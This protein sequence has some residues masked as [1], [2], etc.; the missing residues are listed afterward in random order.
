M[1][2]A[3]LP[4]HVRS[5]HIRP[6]RPQPV[7]K[8]GKQF[9]A[10]IDPS[11]LVRETMVVAP[12]AFQVLQLFTGE[13]KLEDIATKVGGKPEQIA[14]LATGLDRLGLLWGPTFEGLENKAKA[15]LDEAGAFAPRASLSLGEDEAACHAK[16]EE[17]FAETEDPE[18]DAAPIGI[19][20]PHLDYDR[21]WPNYA[22][23]YYAFR[24]MDAPDR[25]VVLG[26]N[27]F[28]LGDGVVMSSHGFESPLGRCPADETVVGKLTEHFGRPLI[29]DELDMLPEHSIELQLPW[30]QYCFGNVPIVAALVPDPLAPMLEEEGR[31]DTGAFTT[32]L[33]E[34]LAEAGGTTVFVASSDL[35]HVGPHFGEPRPIDEQRRF[36]VER[37]D[38]EMMSK[39]I[40]AEPDEFLSAFQWNKNPT[41]WCSI[42]NMHAALTV[43]RPESVELIDYRQAYDDAGRLMVT[44]CAMALMG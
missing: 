24:G 39:F 1:D 42:G 18:L 41:S 5:P 36:D 16:I 20:A 23:A 19:V 8:D 38:R 34:V 10:L 30:I 12:P 33:S 40:T 6:I 3:A 29:V 44:S 27:H 31:V 21:G 22:A 9:V 17:Y 7:Q 37:H 4:E 25:V 43:A 35:S 28:G 14:E 2:L 11:T 32:K 26:T 15:D 13:M